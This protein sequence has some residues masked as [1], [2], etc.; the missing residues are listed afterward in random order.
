MQTMQLDFKSLTKKIETIAK[1]FFASKSK[2]N[3]KGGILDPSLID[4]DDPSAKYIEKVNTSYRSL[5]EA[6]QTIINN[7]FFY[8]GYP[9]WWKYSYKRSTYY[10]HK[11]IAM[12]HFLEAF[13]NELL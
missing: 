11:N 9:M 13:E 10:R 3:S 7:D 6:E 1:E 5:N 12:A 8:Q 4:D 2:I